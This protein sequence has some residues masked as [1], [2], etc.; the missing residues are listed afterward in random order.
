[1]VA[2]PA[3]LTVALYSEDSRATHNNF[4]A[5]K[6]TLL[7][8]LGLVSP[9]IGPRAVH[10]VPVQG[11]PERIHGGEWKAGPGSTPMAQRRRRLFVNDIRT[12]IEAG[13]VVFF[14]IDADTVWLRR[15]RAE[16]HYH[17]ERLRRDVARSCSG[18]GENTIDHWLIPAIPYYEFEAWAYANTSYLVDC[19]DDA[20][21]LARVAAWLDD[22]GRLDEIENIKGHLATVED[23]RS[24]ELVRRDRGFPC[25]RLHAAGKSYAETVDRLRR[26]APILERLGLP[27]EA[28]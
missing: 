7:G 20:E 17:L 15:D 12:Q 3:A 8:M 25:E 9:D 22:L 24:H 14:H 16:F 1:M 18:V 11:G 23:D 28:E 6:E 2:E 21:D 26:S 13:R 4:A 5:L 19:L 27:A 10:L